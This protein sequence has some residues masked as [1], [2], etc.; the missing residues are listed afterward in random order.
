MDT[1]SFVMSLSKPLDELVLPGRESVWEAEKPKWFVMD[2]DC[3]DQQREPGVFH[4]FI[5]TLIEY[6]NIELFVSG[7]LKEEFRLNNGAGV[8]LS[9]KCYFMEDTVSG[10]VKKALKGINS[11]TDIRYENFVDTLYNN[12]SIMREQNRL[13]RHRTQYSMELQSNIKK[14]LNSIYYKMKVSDD[15]VSCSPHTNQ[16]GEFL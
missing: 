12:S 15:F 2:P 9:P 5:I 3:P 8:F 7:L 11:G 10:Q 1:D 16:N 13:R 14:S 6:L 4:F